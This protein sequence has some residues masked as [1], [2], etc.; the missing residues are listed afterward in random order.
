MLR[1][2]GNSKRNRLAAALT[3]RSFSPLATRLR[4][5]RRDL[6]LRE[7]KLAFDVD[8]GLTATAR[9][10][11]L[12]RRRPGL[13]WPRTPAAAVDRELDRYCPGAN[14]RVRGWPG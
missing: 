8:S 13:V 10:L 2:E 1:L 12:V 6:G 3:R 4:P 5:N 9:D 7:R 14:R 11:F